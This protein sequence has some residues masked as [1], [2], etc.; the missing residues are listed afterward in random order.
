MFLFT[1]DLSKNALSITL[2]LFIIFIIFLMVKQ[3]L[4]IEPEKVIKVES[5]ETCIP[6]VKF[7]ESMSSEEKLKKLDNKLYN[8]GKFIPT[9]KTLSDLHKCLTEIQ[10][11]KHIVNKMY[12]NGQGE[13]NNAIAWLEKPTTTRGLYKPV[14][15]NEAKINSEDINDLKEIIKRLFTKKSSKSEVIADDTAVD[16]SNI[17]VEVDNETGASD[18]NENIKSQ[19]PNV[20]ETEIIKIPDLKLE[21]IVDVGLA[22]NKF[23]PTVKKWSLKLLNDMLEA[24]K[25][26]YVICMVVRSS[27]FNQENWENTLNPAVSR[28]SK[29]LIFIQTNVNN[30]DGVTSIDLELFPKKPEIIIKRN[31]FYRMI[32]KI[33]SYF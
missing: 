9:E 8:I 16:N 27:I 33:K 26:T 3:D 19:T 10:Q 29:K 5:E 4:T 2:F 17:A 7:F 18:K 21:N 23:L 28:L 1:I 12:Q 13:L 30:K 25:M 22:F 24:I 6:E 15:R 14:P 11:L 20:I 32:S 31:L